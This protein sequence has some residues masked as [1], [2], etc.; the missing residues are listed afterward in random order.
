[1]CSLKNRQPEDFVKAGI[2]FVLA[3][4]ILGVFSSLPDPQHEKL[5]MQE[6]RQSQEKYRQWLEDRPVVIN[7]RGWT[8]E[9]ISEKY[10]IVENKTVINNHD[11]L[12][13]QGKLWRI[14]DAW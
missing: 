4:A 3:F 13:A 14:D 10:K 2:M 8:P 1:M 9:Q 7:L 6:V 11:Y 12:L 5:L